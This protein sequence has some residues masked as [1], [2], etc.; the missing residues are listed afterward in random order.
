MDEWAIITVVVATAIYTAVGVR[1]RDAIY[2]AV[3]AWASLGIVRQTLP[4]TQAVRL[5]AAAGCVVAVLV[6]LTSAVQRRVA[7]R[8]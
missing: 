2:T 4:T 5:A 1:T 3:F 8:R 6:T 7:P